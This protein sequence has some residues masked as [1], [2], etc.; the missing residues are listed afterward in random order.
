MPTFTEAGPEHQTT[1]GTGLWSDIIG[2]PEAA[3]RAIRAG[4]RI[5]EFAQTAYTDSVFLN[6]SGRWNPGTPDPTTYVPGDVR[7][8]RAII[9]GSV[10]REYAAAQHAW[11]T[12]P[13]GDEKDSLLRNS[14][15]GSLTAEMLY[16]AVPFFLDAD[17]ADGLAHSE[18]PPDDALATL[19]LPY[20]TVMVFFGAEFALPDQLVLPEGTSAGIDKALQRPWNPD[21]PFAMEI[22]AAV[23][24]RGGSVTGLVFAA[25]PDGIGLSDEFLWLLSAE[26][27]PNQPPPAHLDRQRGVVNSRL[28]H[29][30]LADTVLNFAASVAW[31]DWRAP[32]TTD[33]PDPSDNKA[34]R[35]FART[36]QFRK[37]EPRGAYAG[38][39]VINIDSAPAKP[40][41]PTGD[42]TD[43]RTS[44]T[45]HLRR[46][47]WRSVRVATRAADG[48]IIGNTRNADGEGVDWHYEGR[49]IPPSIVNPTAGSS[50][51][52]AVY[53]LPSTGTSDQATSTPT[54]D[55]ETP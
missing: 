26:P 48:T 49:W 3:D 8:V 39:H 4:R 7:A 38:V 33:I 27:D 17:T 36:S 10:I 12:A 42:D 34:W 31:L 35:K 25:G 47:H 46:G 16:D 29:C 22:D 6:R 9:G 51:R 45:T 37:N 13:A 52:Q 53:R 32:N 19:R 15:T 24:Y 20:P 50:P 2:A 1:F 43:R 14:I 28:Q 44:P 23:A 30:L 55:S 54:S 5:E 40:A 21:F 41:G 18:R 11:T